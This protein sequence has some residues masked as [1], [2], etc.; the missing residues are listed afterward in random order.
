MVYSMTGYG[1]ASKQYNDKT[2]LVD[3][4]TL[5]GKSTDVRI[6]APHIYRSKELDIRNLVLNYAHRGKIDVTVTIE[7]P[8]GEEAY[9]INTALIQQYYSELQALTQQ[10]N[11]QNDILQSIMKIPN[12]VTLS[13]EELDLREWK[14]VLEAIHAAG[15]Q[16]VSFRNQ[17]GKGIYDDLLTNTTTILSLLEQVPQYEEERI[18]KLRKRLQSNIEQEVSKEQYDPNRFEQEMFFY[19]EKLDIS[20]EKARLSHHCKYFIEVLNTDDQVKG[21]KLSFISQEIGREINTLGAKAQDNNLQKLVVN[22]KDALE[23][24]KEQIANVL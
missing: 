6:K 12:V 2:I 3:V 17:E 11:N 23:K 24:I 4:K 19:I 18:N 21:R 22:M 8:S 13:T 1:Q 20:E 15:K 9:V 7:S 16:L 5:N 10:Y 14:T